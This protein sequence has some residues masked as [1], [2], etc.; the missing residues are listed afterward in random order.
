M[1]T[2]RIPLVKLGAKLP[3]SYSFRVFCGSD[4]VQLLRLIGELRFSI[5]QSED[6]RLVGEFPDNSWIDSLEEMSEHWAAFDLSGNLVAAAR[7]TLFQDFESFPDQSWYNLP[8]KE[9][10]LPM[11]FF[12]RDVV[13]L[14]HR[15]NGLG[16][17]FNLERL[18]RARE[19]GARTAVAD[20]PDY[21]AR[22]FR[23][24]GFK[25]IRRPK[26]GFILPDIKW[27]IVS[28]DLDDV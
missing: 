26:L 11:V 2:S 13:E 23:N 7:L 12:S 25:E 9:I 27:A 22:T 28:K 8:T 18:L 1:D 6:T 15:K 24:L 10:C 20:I 4:D 17:F 5:W 16:N 19:L 21:R 14:K 3:D